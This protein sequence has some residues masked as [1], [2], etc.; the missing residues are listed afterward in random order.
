RAAYEALSDDLKLKIVDAKTENTLISSARMKTGNPDVVKA[1][2]ESTKPP[3]V[4]K[5]C[6]GGTFRSGRGRVMFEADAR[7]STHVDF[8]A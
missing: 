5:R 3:T 4:R 6:L 8:R 7:A 1:Q 2:L